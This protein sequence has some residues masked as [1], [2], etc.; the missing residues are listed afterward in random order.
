M[1]SNQQINHDPNE[2]KDI[3]VI[4]LKGQPLINADLIKYNFR[5]HILRSSTEC[6]GFTS[7]S[8]VFSKT[9]EIDTQ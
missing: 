4:I 1:T 2:M 5:S 8:N 6:P 3:K 7:R 9:R